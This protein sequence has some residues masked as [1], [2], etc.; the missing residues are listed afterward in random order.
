MDTVLNLI[1][2]EQVQ[3]SYGVWRET[4]SPRQVFA[5]IH[6][7]TRNEF[8]EAGRNGLNP[9]FE[10]TVFHGD[11]QGETL[12]EY[13][14]KQYSIYRTYIVPGTDYIELYVERQGGSNNG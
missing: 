12:C 13:E 2:I 14:G 3:D 1:S 11:Y 6:S 5:E 4:L 7:I 9:A 10:F 8:F